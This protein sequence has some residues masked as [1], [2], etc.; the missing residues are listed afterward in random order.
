MLASRQASAAYAPYES[1]H[2]EA[3]LQ[4][5]NLLC[6]TVAVRNSVVLQTLNLSKETV[7]LFGKV[8]DHS[9]ESFDGFLHVCLVTEV[10]ILGAVLGTSLT[11]L[12][13]TLQSEWF[14]DDSQLIVESREAFLHC[15]GRIEDCVERNVLLAFDCCHRDNRAMA[16]RVQLVKMD[17]ETDD[18]LLAP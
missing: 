11:D 3:F 7:A 10:F 15:F 9:S 4:F 17:I 13:A 16:M 1:V 18:V 6:V 2:P 12:I 5:K 14:V 8:A